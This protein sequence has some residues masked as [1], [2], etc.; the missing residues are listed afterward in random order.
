MRLKTTG[1]VIAAA[2]V[3]AVASIGV[4]D[5]QVNTQQNAKVPTD[6]LL[7]QGEGFAKAIADRERSIQYAL[8]DATKAKDT[9]KKLCLQDK[10]NQMAA[11]EK[12][13]T[14]N[15]GKLKAAIKAGNDDRARAYH[16]MLKLGDDESRAKAA[17]AQQCIGEEVGTPGESSVDVTIDPNIP[18]TDPSEFPADPITSVPPVMTSPVQ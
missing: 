14:E 16:A 4:A 3:L 13:A 9:V 10:Q 12:Q 11:L 8:R 1:W 6:K 17:E 18:D 2:A 15:L 5:A 7:A